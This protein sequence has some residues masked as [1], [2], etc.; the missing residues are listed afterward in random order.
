[1]CAD[2]GLVEFAPGLIAELEPFVDRIAMLGQVGI[3]GPVPLAIARLYALLGDTDRAREQISLGEEM[4]S[5][6]GGVPALLRL[7][8]LRAELDG[9]SSTA[10]AVAVEAERIGM[11]GVAAAARRLASS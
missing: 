9:D 8:L 10:E 5:R 1:V 3:A 4:T 11:A 2:H 6:N 7:R